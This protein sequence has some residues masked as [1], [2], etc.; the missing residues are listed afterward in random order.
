MTIAITAILTFLITMPAILWLDQKSA[1]RENINESIE[2]W[3]N[4]TK[5]MKGGK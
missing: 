1:N 2:D 4:F 5:T 3:H